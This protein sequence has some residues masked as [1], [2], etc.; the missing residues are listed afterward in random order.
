MR[1]KKARSIWLVGA[2]LVIPGLAPA[3]TYTSTYA[4]T[5]PRLDV[6]GN[7]TCCTA[8]EADVM[9]GVYTSRST[10][11]QLL[12]AAPVA[13]DVS[14][15]GSSRLFPET[16]KTVRG[17]F[18]EYWNTHGGLMQQGYPISEEMQEQSPTNGKTYTVQYFE[19]AI[20]EF[21][22]ENKGTPYQVLLSL[23]GNFQYQAKYPNGA[24]S[25]LHSAQQPNTS[26]GSVFFPQTGK[27]LG[28]VFLSYWNA[29][30]GLAQQGYP[31]SDEFTEVSELDGKP[32]TVQYFERA[33]FEW[34]P[35]MADTPYEV[36]LSQ[37]GTYR[38]K[39]RYASATAQS[40][41]Q[42]QTTPGA[43]QVSTPAPGGTG[44]ANCS[45]TSVGFT[46][47]SD[48][49]TGTYK[50]YEGGLYPAGLNQPPAG[51]AGEGMQHAQAIKPLS[52]DG[53]PDKAGKIVLLSIGMSNATQEF[54]TFK[55]V[56]D[57]DPQKNRQLVIVDG[58]QGGQDAEKIKD[59]TAN[60][61]RVVEQR[62][63]Q[64]GVSG[65]QVEAVWLKEAIMD[66]NNPFPA[67]AQRLQT[68]LAQIVQILQTRYP[69][70]QIVYLASR[71]YAGYASTPLNPEPY[72]YESGFAVKGLIEQR[73]KGGTNSPWLAWG[74]Y[75][76]TD[77]TKGRSDG[78]V[79]TCADVRASDGTHPSQSGMLKIANLLLAFFKSDETARG[80][81]IEP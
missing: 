24:G 25:A 75:F 62:L 29:H 32:Y 50:G 57:P 52:R 23:V 42:A 80:W 27:R 6:S 16:G 48:L 12:Q 39:T 19:R 21:H 71:T 47:L 65:K 2:L 43:T 66:E 68:D 18:L 64:S 22:P 79:W 31:I 81:F 40:P 73:I 60:F 9:T 11:G 20:F 41:L 37:L 69:N 56:A 4:A 46:P 58:A 70:L 78:F 77:G 53:Q 7:V 51:Y 15:G 49:G 13:L 10:G 33:V 76:W 26:T 44:Q 30:G 59:P 63:T 35:E 36:L 45:R 17:M 28:G 5:G 55:G 1:G 8:G 3:S 72:A 54:S 67:D 74:P 34:H 38:Y 61:W 14:P